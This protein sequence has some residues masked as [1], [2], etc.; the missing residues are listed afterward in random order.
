MQDIGP[1]R[2]R[3]DDPGNAARV[4][5]IDLF[6]PEPAVFRQPG[7]PVLFEFGIVVIVQIVDPDEPSSPAF[8][9][10]AAAQLMPIKPATPVI[11]TVMAEWNPG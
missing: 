6:K 2:Q 10:S 7:Q 9:S 5:D 3:V 4:G 1:V 8:A 11:R